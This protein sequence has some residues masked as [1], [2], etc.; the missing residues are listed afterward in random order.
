MIV[1]PPRVKSP[2]RAR[3]D[4]RPVRDDAVEVAGS[5]TRYWT[6]EPPE[7][8]EARVTVVAPPTLMPSGIGAWSEADGFATS[9]DLDAVL[10]A[11]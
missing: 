11:D 5:L 8:Q 10:D 7:G 3:L 6:Y 1:R 9:W 4:A 2:Y